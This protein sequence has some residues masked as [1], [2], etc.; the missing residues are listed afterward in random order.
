MFKTPIPHSGF[1]ELIIGKLWREAGGQAFNPE[2]QKR[3]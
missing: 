2:T 3:R 1:P